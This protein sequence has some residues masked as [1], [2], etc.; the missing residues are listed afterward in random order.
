LGLGIGLILAFGVLRGLNGYGNPTSLGP[1]RVL[2]NGEWSV[3]K[4]SLYTLFSFMDVHKYP[5]SLDYLLVTLGPAL[6]VLS[7]LDGGTPRLL[8][9]FIVFGRV[10][11]LYYMLHLPL[12]HGMAV[13][14]RNVSSHSAT[15]GAAAAPGL[16]LAG[17]YLVWAWVV[18]ILYPICAWFAGLKSRRKDVWLSYL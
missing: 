4:D 9:P 5:P 17:V 2:A 11:L 12:I 1:G 6:I 15:A 13:I 3:Q 18:L 8:K 7:L 10:P 14:A 16:G